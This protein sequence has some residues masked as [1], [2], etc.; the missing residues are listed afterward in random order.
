MVEVQG[1]RPAGK[2]T[3][4]TATL[5]LVLVDPPGDLRRVSQPAGLFTL[6]PTSESAL[7]RV[8]HGD[9]LQS[10]RPEP[11]QRQLRPAH[12]S[13]EKIGQ[14]RTQPERQDRKSVV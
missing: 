13:V 4:D 11:G 14:T 8:S 12:L 5:E 6:S 7:R 9:R 10:G 2:A 3:V 1:L